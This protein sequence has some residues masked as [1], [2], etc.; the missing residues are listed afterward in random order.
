MFGRNDKDDLNYMSERYAASRTD[1]SRFAYFLSFTTVLF[2]VA[3][4]V[5]SKWAVLDEVTRGEG[6]I[7]PSS[8]V[9]TIQ[10]LE[11]GIVSE[12]LV[13]LGDIVEE[14]QLLMRIDNSA[15]QSSFEEEKT[16]FNNLRARIIRLEAEVADK[17]KISFPDDLR[18]AAP[19]AVEFEETQF[20][21]NKDR[22]RAETSVLASRAK[23]RRQEVSEMRSRQSQ[24]EDQLSTI[25]REYNMTAPLVRQGVMARIDLVRLEGQRTDVEGEIRT[26]RL[27]IPRAQTAVSEA[28]QQIR[29]IKL[30]SKAEASQQLNETRA[31][32]ESLAQTM[33]AGEDRVDRTDVRSKIRGTVKDIFVTSVGGVIQ[34]GEPIMEIVP[35]G[36]TLLIEA[37]VKPSDIAFIRPQQEAIIKV[38]AYDF[39][40]YGGLRG[41]VE[42]ISADTIVDEEGDSFYKVYL[43]TNETV[44][45]HKGKEL[46]IF[47]GMT[48]SVDILTGQKSVFDYLMKPILKAQ[49]EALRER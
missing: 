31:E 19:N 15:A 10:N 41:I 46:P 48:T 29:E 16:R 32:I 14:N 30:A 2:L 11:G 5:W 44:L 8:R 28:N 12:L 18:E 36:D 34:P 42:N 35:L 4:V 17:S 3:F 37:K 22:R 49:N 9:Q 21:I 7:I 45:A 23:Q 33:S 25:N 13:N 6:Q 39:S 27:S 24:L 43:R 47:S 26:V 40:I 1:A 38:T 20:D